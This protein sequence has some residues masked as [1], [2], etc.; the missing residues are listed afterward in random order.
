MYM[1]EIKTMK[2]VLLL[3]CKGVEI[4]EAAAFYDL[5]GWSG[6][7]GS[8]QVDVVTVGL[9]SPVTCTFGLTVITDALL[10]DVQHDKFDALAVPGGFGNSGL[11]SCSDSSPSGVSNG[12]RLTYTIC[13]SP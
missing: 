6:T 5:L 10:A 12:C 1:V 8:E 11:Y 3:L 7:D 2:R 13:L 4:F 9:Q